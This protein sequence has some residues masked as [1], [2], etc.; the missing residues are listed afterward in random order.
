MG[1]GK[2]RYR[3][4][5]FPIRLTLEEHFTGEPLIYVGIFLHGIHVGMGVAILLCSTQIG[6]H[7]AR[8]A[9]KVV[10][11]LTIVGQRTTHATKATLRVDGSVLAVVERMNLNATPSNKLHHVFVGPVQDRIEGF[12]GL[13]LAAL[14]IDAALGRLLV[15]LR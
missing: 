13:L 2:L 15:V 4:V 3:L 1:G 7:H 14:S 8:I 5:V 12:Y 6:T 11:A 10:D 9:P